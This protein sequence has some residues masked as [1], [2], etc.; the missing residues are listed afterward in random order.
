MN[1][2]KL[3]WALRRRSVF[4]LLPKVPGSQIAK[5]I[6][7]VSLRRPSSTQDER[8]SRNKNP[9]GAQVTNQL[10]QGESYHVRI[11]A[12]GR[13]ALVNLNIQWSTIQKAFQAINRRPN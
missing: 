8:Q 11:R 6:S 9:S 12:H 2:C 3:T 10:P 5:F 7:R 13:D 1:P 4:F